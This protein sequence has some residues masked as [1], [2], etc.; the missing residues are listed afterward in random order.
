M[1]ELTRGVNDVWRGASALR[2]RPRLWKWLIAPSLIAIA[3]LAVTVITI[4]RVFA[5]ILDWAGAHLPGWLASIV[6]PLLSAAVLA[7]LIAAALLV[8]VAVVGA[9]TGPFLEIL[10]GHLEAEL[11]GIAPEKLS[12]PRFAHDLAVSLVHGIRR[13]IVALVGIILV[14]AIGLVPVIGTIAAVVVGG[15]LAA[16]AAAYDC[17]DAV[18][19][20]RSLSYRGKLA[21]LSDH[22]GR[23]FGLGAVTA[24][25]LIV[26]GINLIALGIGAA[27][28]TLACVENPAT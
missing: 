22:R 16:K 28:A 4:D 23:T 26:P 13:L 11:T 10:S 6:G 7:A 14:F 2:Q 18:L 15:L 21:Y 5:H 20:R 24:G 12:L 27:G 17:Y 9:I 25:L 3:L 19:A 1:T 8:F